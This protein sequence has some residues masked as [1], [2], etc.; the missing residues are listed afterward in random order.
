MGSLF[1]KI[2]TGASFSPYNITSDWGVTATN[3]LAYN[4]DNQHGTTLKQWGS[5]VR[6]HR[7]KPGLHMPFD[8]LRPQS[9]SLPSGGSVTGTGAIIPKVPIA[10]GQTFTPNPFENAYSAFYKNRSLPPQWLMHSNLKRNFQPF[11]IG[12]V[13]N[14]TTGLRQETAPPVDISQTDTT[15]GVPGQEEQGDIRLP[16]WPGATAVSI[17]YRESEG[18]QS[19]V[20][21]MLLVMRPNGIEEIMS[22]GQMDPGIPYNTTLPFEAFNQQP[23][24]TTNPTADSEIVGLTNTL[25]AK[26]TDKGK[27]IQVKLEEYV[28]NSVPAPFSENLPFGQAPLGQNKNQHNSTELAHDQQNSTLAEVVV[29]RIEPNAAWA[30]ECVDTR[31][32]YAKSDRYLVGPDMVAANNAMA[33]SDDPIFDPVQTVPDNLGSQG[34]TPLT[35][36]EYLQSVELLTSVPET[37]ELGDLGMY[38]YY[39]DPVDASPFAH[40]QRETIKA[41]LKSVENRWGLAAS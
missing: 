32:A 9:W 4:P 5:N 7:A 11:I 18:P 15:L 19:P 34:R 41:S 31:M 17:D 30:N 23:K 35:T 37:N 40:Q 10:P 6:D 27:A 20:D 25:E 38:G 24:E 14:T 13:Y 16:E 33:D 36:L 8:S 39:R 2:E 3:E 29:R 28:E 21:N 22:G 12:D 1:S 26:Q